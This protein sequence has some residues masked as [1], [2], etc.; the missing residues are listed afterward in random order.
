M[1]RNLI[2]DV[3]PPS[4]RSIRHITLPTKGG[5]SVDSAVSGGSGRFSL[6]RPGKAVTKIGSWF[7]V[8]IALALAVFAISIIYTGAT[9]KV[10]PK[11]LTVPIDLNIIAKKNPQNGELK[12]DYVA[13]GKSASQVVPATGNEY[14]EKKASGQIVI[15]NNWSTASQRLI[16]NT[17]FETRDGLIYRINESVTVPGKR[18]SGGQTIPGS[19]TVMV[20]ADQS[21]PK[22]N[23]GLTDFT[24]P[25]FAS[26]KVRFA[27]F[28]GRSKTSMTGGFIGTVKKVSDDVL[29]ATRKNMRVNLETAILTEASASL[30]T[31]S[32]LF[33]GGIYSEFISLDTKTA[34]DTSASVGESA[35]STVVYFDKAKLSTYLATQAIQNYDNASVLINNFK[36]LVFTSLAKDSAN[37]VTDG[38]VQFNLK[39]TANFVWTYDSQ[40]LKA[41]LAGKAK[42]DIGVV[43]ANYPGIMRTEAVVRPFWKTV[44]P[45][46]PANIKIEE[47]APAVAKQR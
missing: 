6:P 45:T 10:E 43:L 20:Y 7:V 8:I 16:K 23:V 2:Q 15:Y 19:V 9:V 4:R 33:P 17:R 18:V 41:D 46:N 29:T 1:P 26:D 14:V 44:F 22:Y 5:K 11:Q 3:I 21:G 12:F 36:E 42:R 38:F 25:G 31:S 37:P 47:M 13:I 34:S 40:K 27:G 28:Y 35:S 24:I 32:V 30:P 39:G